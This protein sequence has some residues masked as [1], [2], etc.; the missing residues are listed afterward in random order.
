MVVT[1][2]NGGEE[3]DSLDRQTIT[4]TAHDAD[5]GSLHFDLLF[6][7]DRGES[8][9]PLAT[10]LSEP[11]YTFQSGQI[12]ASSAALIRVIATDGFHTTVD[13]SDAPFSLVEKY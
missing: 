8:W 9:L 12:P 1:F 5:G 10:G 4:W 2:P 7:P 3:L 6:S 13:E 11:A